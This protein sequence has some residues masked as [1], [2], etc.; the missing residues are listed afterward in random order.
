M[1]LVVPLV[2]LRITCICLED[3]LL[4]KWIVWKPSKK[5]KQIYW[6]I[7]V[8]IIIDAIILHFVWVFLETS[9]YFSGIENDSTLDA[10]SLT[11]EST[12]WPH[13]KSPEINQKSFRF[14]S[15]SGNESWKCSL[16][17]GSSDSPRKSWWR[18]PRIGWS[19]VKEDFFSSWSLPEN[20][21]VPSET[22][23]CIFTTFRRYHLLRIE[24]FQHGFWCVYLFQLLKV[25][26]Q[27]VSFPNSPRIQDKVKEDSREHFLS[28]LM[29]SRLTFCENR[30]IF[31][32][33]IKWK[34]W[35]LKWFFNACVL[36][37]PL[38]HSR[39]VIEAHPGANTFQPTGAFLLFVARVFRGPIRFQQ[40]PF[41]WPRSRTATL[42]NSFHD[43]YVGLTVPWAVS[44]FWSY[45]RLVTQSI[46][47]LLEDDPHL[48][49]N[50]NLPFANSLSVS[51]HSGADGLVQG[52]LP[53]FFFLECWPFSPALPVTLTHTLLP[54][55]TADCLG[56]DRWRLSSPYHEA[57]TYPCGQLGSSSFATNW[58]L[59][60]RRLD[61]TTTGR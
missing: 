14:S 6:S 35:T 33:G 57:T 47:T 23:I 1:L 56:R 7:D 34:G 55:L 16:G 52:E 29:D 12:C 45:D 3:S 53:P 37:T 19:R 11:L 42:G 36:R 30:M 49:S 22:G 4:I 2:V 60:P 50:G 44:F 61:G 32:Q 51:P 13:M 39:L 59:L 41:Q 18:S 10:H 9:I 31:K 24:S 27:Y 15:T 17:G 40:P 46:A 25:H 48:R 38:Q 54:P 20:F 43:S 26:I 28:K 8:P 58:R 5:I 21:N